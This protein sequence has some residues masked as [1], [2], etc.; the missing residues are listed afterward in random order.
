MPRMSGWSSRMNRLRLANP[1]SAAY[2]CGLQSAVQYRVEQYEAGG[3]DGGR[4]T[5]RQLPRCQVGGRYDGRAKQRRPDPHAQ[6][7]VSCE[8]LSGLVECERG[9]VAGDAAL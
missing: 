7:S 2:Q 6:H 9:V 5:G 1:C 8:V 3:Q 4:E